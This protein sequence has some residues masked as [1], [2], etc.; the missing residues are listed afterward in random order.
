MIP[1]ATELKTS[2]TYYG[3]GTQEVFDI[4][5]DYLK[6][7][8]VVVFVDDEKLSYGTE[9]IVDNR[10]INFNTAPAS[11]SI[12]VIQRETSTE[13]LVSWQDA[14]VLK[15]ADMTISQVQQLHIL[16]EQE[17]WTKTNSI[18]VDENN[19]WNARFHRITNVDDPVEPQDAVTK[20]Y[21]ENIKT[22]FIS[23]MVKIRD[24]AIITINTLE[25]NTVEAINNFKTDVE[26]Y[27][28][29]LT[30]DFKNF[31]N[32]KTTDVS[33]LADKA[34][35]SETNAKASEIAAKTSET[36]AK[37]SELKAKTSEDNALIAEQQAAAAASTASNKAYA[38][39]ISETNAKSSAEKAKISETNSKTS[40][41]KAEKSATN[42]ASS[43]ETATEGATTATQEADRAK[44][45]ADR[46]AENASK[47]DVTAYYNKTETNNLLNSKA[48]LVDGKVSTDQL[49]AM[50]YVSN[51][52]VGNAINKIPRYNS[53][54]HL[55]LP[56][57]SEFWIG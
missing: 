42:A 54:G 2:I 18:V 41:G 55:V 36:N 46:A 21:I 43:A 56:D 3:T 6:G 7:S 23:E 51:T 8:F 35:N 49:P 20:S 32:I 37:A 33:L 11:G 39:E 38:A 53:E 34:A 15:A 50:D 57:G 16:E 44:T 24:G 52:D 47:V 31:V 22:G 1:I 12:I 48:D 5:F 9:Y 28:S 19:Q 26:N 30:D 10:Q 40:E 4:P 13:R 27:T 17:D 45:E 29:Q 25:N 14:S